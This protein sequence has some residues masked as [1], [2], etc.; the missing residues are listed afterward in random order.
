MRSMSSPSAV[1]ISTGNLDERRSSRRS[2]RPERCGNITSRIT[3]IV[4]AGVGAA[5]G[6]VAVMREIDF[7]SFADEEI[8][9]QGA[10]FLVVIREQHARVVHCWHIHETRKDRAQIP[11]RGGLCICLHLVTAICEMRLHGSAILIRRDRASEVHDR[12]CHVHVRCGLSASAAPA[13]RRAA[14]RQSSATTE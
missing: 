3:R 5:Q 1:S 8:A 9:Q 4:A 14:E 12:R 10:Q 6:F 7:E 2:S 11:S 13:N